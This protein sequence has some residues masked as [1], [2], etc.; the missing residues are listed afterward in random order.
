MFFLKLKILILFASEGNMTTNEQ[1]NKENTVHAVRVKG[2]CDTWLLCRSGKR[3]M[4]L[5]SQYFMFP[6]SRRKWGKPL[7]YSGMT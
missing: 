2:D 7:D 6:N 1:K 4:H 5:A 3:N